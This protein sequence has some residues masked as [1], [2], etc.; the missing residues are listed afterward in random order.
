MAVLNGTDGND[1]ISGY[2][3]DDVIRGGSGDDTVQGDSG[4]SRGGMVSSSTKV[5]TDSM[6]L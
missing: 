2:I 4:Y 1:S 6:K 5:T 3:L